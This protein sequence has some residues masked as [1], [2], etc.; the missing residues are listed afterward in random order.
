MK[1]LIWI[2]FILTIVTHAQVKNPIKWKSEIRHDKE[3]IYEAV[4][5]AI[6]ESGWHVYSQD[7]K[8]ENAIPTLFTYSKNSSI[9]LIGNTKEIGKKIEEYSDVFEGTLIYYSNKVEYR[10]RVEVLGSKPVVFEA[11]V[12]YQICNDKVCLAPDGETFSFTLT[13]QS[14]N[15]EKP[16]VL[17]INT[18][19]QL[20][21]SDSKM[22][23]VVSLPK[24]DSAQEVKT[25]RL[26]N[27]NQIIIPG[28]NV[29]EPI[30]KDCGEK[31]IKEEGFI[32]IFAFG[33]LG[34]LVAL[35]TPCVYPMIPLT[36]SYFTKHAKSKK[37]GKKDA[38]IYA[39]FIVLIFVLFTLP[40]HLVSGINSDIF[41]QIA[42]N[43][44]LNLIFF[45]IF[46][47]FAFSFFGY[48]DITLPSW[49][50]NKS[51][52]A[53]ESGGMIGLFFMALTLVIVSF[54]CTGPVLGSILA[55]AI[56]NPNQ[57]TMAF[58]GCGLAWALVFGLF[59]LFPRFLHTMPK[60]GGWMN[61]IK[62]VLGF[63]ELALAF[64]FLSKADLVAK[65]FFLK[66]E[67]FIAIWILIS[68]SIVLYLLG[69]IKFPHDHTQAKIGIGRKIGAFIFGLIGIY[70]I[71][72]LFPTEKPNLKL[73][74]GLTPPLQVSVYQKNQKNGVLGLTTLHDYDEAIQLAKK[75]N[76]PI[77]IDFT[78]YGC[79]NCRKMEEYVWS[80][81]D[82][83][84]ILHDQ[85]IIA[86]L[87]V[88]D[89][90]EL[91]VNEQ[92]ILHLKDGRKR[93][94]KTIGNKW[95][96]FQRENFNSNSQ[97]FYVLVTPDNKILNFPVA[98]YMDKEEFK[99]FLLCGFTAYERLK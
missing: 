48:Y 96:T 35:L 8:V 26:R 83:W 37:E 19:K 82:I 18:V 94:I 72:G 60:S 11:E 67:I 39:F 6:L 33:F 27:K 43:I 61:T 16:Q 58:G 30:N 86:S 2:F 40:F 36:I 42:T 51:D 80:E 49:M 17:P 66:R 34:G 24:D 95:S 50:A 41:N 15:K 79:E 77:L 84:N 76:K 5:T 7:I 53:S 52:K 38:L 93:K 78:G 23:S 70:M 20:T 88:D 9:R 56:Q 74:S 62:V 3:N 85:L 75:E 89:S 45:V 69:I 65:T 57:L 13:P 12:E 47:L 63:L 25:S 54:S 90:E 73:L 99:R 1:K 21:K 32:W 92:L 97:P 71:P 81:P 31:I 44:G 98:G 14:I 87:Y 55:N 59:A 64:K 91:P 4:F 10:Q 28:L 22:N 29:A 68:I 46:I